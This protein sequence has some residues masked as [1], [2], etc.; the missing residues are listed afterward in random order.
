[1]RAL[2]AFFRAEE[3]EN[4]HRFR[5]IFPVRPH[6][7]NHMMERG[8]FFGESIINAVAESVGRVTGYKTG[9]FKLL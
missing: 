3:F 6:G 7:V 2:L 8:A 1:M 4:R 9:L 5:G